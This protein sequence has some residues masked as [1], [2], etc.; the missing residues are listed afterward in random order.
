MR[1]T[2]PSSR[3]VGRSLAAICCAFPFAD[4][5]FWIFC[6]SGTDKD[7]ALFAIYQALLVINALLGIVT[8]CG[9]YEWG[10]DRIWAPALLG[11]AF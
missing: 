5:G 9:M 2:Q 3:T 6:Q 11:I 4:F 1:P 10:H 7:A 8:L